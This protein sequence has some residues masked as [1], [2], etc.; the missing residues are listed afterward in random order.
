MTDAVDRA[1]EFLDK[2]ERLGEQLK[3]AEKQQNIFLAAMLELKRE[4]KV[5]TEEY[6]QLQQQS[7]DLQNMIDKWRPIYQERLE[8]VKEVKKAKA[9][10]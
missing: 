1:L 10:K 8:M 2:L 3:K 4:E 9:K 5:N 7:V 6:A